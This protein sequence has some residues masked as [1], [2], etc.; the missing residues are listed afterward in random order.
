M[1]DIL[2]IGNLSGGFYKWEAFEWQTAC[3]QN[4]PAD[5]VDVDAFRT[6]DLISY[7]FKNLL[8]LGSKPLVVHI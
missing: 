7:M 5:I 3:L 1:M 2:D 4:K 8:L 6:L